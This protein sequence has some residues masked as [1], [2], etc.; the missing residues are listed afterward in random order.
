[1]ASVKMH[2]FRRNKPGV[3]DFTEEVQ[4][5]ENIGEKLNKDA[6][7]RK[8][9]E[10]LEIRKTFPVFQNRHEIMH[11]LRE[12]QV[13]ILI[14]ETGSGKSTQVPQFLLDEVSEGGI[15]VT[16]PRRV[17]AINL[18][19]RVAQEHGCN[20]GDRVG[21]SVRFDNTTSKRTKLKYLTDGMLLRELMMHKDLRQ[22]SV[23]VIDEA[24][25]RTVLT[26][27]ILGFLK[28][29]INGPRPDLKI[30]VMSATLQAEKFSAFFDSAPILFVEDV[31]FKSRN[32]TLQH[33]VMM[34]STA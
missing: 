20:L 6:L 2:P 8:A 23:V 10:L 29:L 19:T 5:D 30:V 27:L 9:R 16:Q 13:S 18:A 14:G 24:H 26:D 31:S 32:I 7:K 22:Y 4:D 12:N 33:L 15:A 21:Y 1:M 17:A 3:V 28:S 11:H 34:W 25:E